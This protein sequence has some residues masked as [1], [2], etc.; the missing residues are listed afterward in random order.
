LAEEGLIET[1]HGQNTKSI[2]LDG[3]SRRVVMM[4]KHMAR[5][6]ADGGMYQ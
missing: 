4:D 5:L 2:H 1:D 6:V 3:K